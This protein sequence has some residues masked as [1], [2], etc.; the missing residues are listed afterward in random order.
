MKYNYEEAEK[1]HSFNNKNKYDLRSKP[2]SHYILSRS[3]F[4]TL[5]SLF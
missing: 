5:R 1:S 3:F 4:T 2:I